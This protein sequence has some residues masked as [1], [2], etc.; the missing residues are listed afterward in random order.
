MKTMWLT[1]FCA[2]LVIG[3]F[4]CATTPPATR[5]AQA[6]ITLR[7]EVKGRGQAGV[8]IVTVATGEQ[9]HSAQIDLSLPDGVRL[10]AGT[11]KTEADF[12]KD[13]PREFRYLLKADKPG[14]YTFNIKVM[15]G[16]ESY[17][18]GKS[19]SVAWIAQDTG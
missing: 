13:K 1:S 10:V 8:L 3:G 12:E 11:L 9:G 19:V 17:R 16:E 7:A 15:A 6:P 18:F 4:G 2:A 14:V 5:D